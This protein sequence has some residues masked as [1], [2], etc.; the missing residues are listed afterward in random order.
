[1][2]YAVV[3]VRGSARSHRDVRDTLRMLHLTRQNH[4]VFVPEDETHKGMLQK[5][6][7]YVTWGEVDE[8]TVHE[9]LVAR[10][11]VQGDRPL[12]DEYIRASSGFASA[13]ELASALAASRASFS[14]IKGVK[15]VMRLH[16]PRG[17]YENTKRSFREGGS[18]GYRGAEIRSLIRRMLGPEAGG[19]RRGKQTGGPG[20]G[21]GGREGGSAGKEGGG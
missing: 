14:K 10:G 20:G 18:L 15:P 3:R 7:D 11:R 4:L 19:V 5:V 6:K 2:T 21:E 13:R 17:G 12:T 8:E 1:M 16:P 9:A